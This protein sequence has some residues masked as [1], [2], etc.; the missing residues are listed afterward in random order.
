MR[1]SIEDAFAAH[2]N[3]DSARTKASGVTGV[4]WA[5]DSMDP[6]EAFPAP[7]DADSASTNAIDDANFIGA[8]FDPSAK[9]SAVVSIE[10]DSIP[11]SIFSN[12][13]PAA[14]PQAKSF[15]QAKSAA[16]AE[17]ETVF[18]DPLLA[19]LRK[20]ASSMSSFPSGISV[21]ALSEYTAQI[22]NQGSQYDSKSIMESVSSNEVGPAELYVIHDSTE[23]F[24]VTLASLISLVSAMPNALETFVWIDVAC[25]SVRVR[26]T[27]SLLQEIRHLMSKIG[28]VILFTDSFVH[29]RIMKQSW[30]LYQIQVALSLGCRLTF[31]STD[32]LEVQAC[33][34]SAWDK[35]RA[36]FCHGL[37]V[38][39]S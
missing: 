6:S 26:K 22:D 34:D 10:L 33:D 24:S 18:R 39:C 15:A 30:C 25:L 28:R 16:D 31:F 14:A 13:V 2:R 7:R 11:G 29:F 35:V 37:L 1:S 21:R 19:N 4:R 5:Q 36:A 27:R 23:P 20:I 32:L 8:S 9:A 17:A 12:S 3:S 38:F